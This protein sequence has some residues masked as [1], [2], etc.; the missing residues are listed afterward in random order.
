MA[1]VS[2]HTSPTATPGRGD[3]GGINVLQLSLARGLANRG[4]AVDLLTRAEA[5]PEVTELF[6]GVTL[7]TIAAGGAR[8]LPESGMADV[9]D[10]FGEAVATLVGRAAPRYDLLH[11]HFWLSGL[12]TLPVAL[13]LGLPFVQSFHTLGSM[14]NAALADSERP[15]P[16]RRLRAEAFL[17]SEADAVVAAS[18]AEVSAL[19]DDLH[20]PASHMWVIPP[21]VDTTLFTPNRAGHA[22]ELRR[23]LDLEDDRPLMVMAGRIEPIKAQDLAIRILAAVH[24]LHGWAP[25]LVVAGEA[26][27]GAEGYRDSLDALAE[28][29]GV[30]PHLRFVGPLDRIE[31]ADL[32]AAAAV[33]L[34][35]SYSETFGLVALESAA[36]GTP[37]VGYRSAGLL[38][39][40]AEG[41]S[42]VLVPTRDPAAW[43]RTVSDLLDDELSLARLSASAR[44]HAEGFTWATATRSLLGVYES[45][46]GRTGD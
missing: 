24:S 40:V 43:A 32:F 15:E 38:E 33:T 28:D 20:A 25:L 41:E 12:A 22:P 30:T 14:K 35:T 37:V 5:E 4:I 2:M 1:M 26:P 21:G 45:L 19:I 11:A 3:A 10:A 34:I 46:L 44:R 9:A 13:E 39:S 29:L 18:S 8:H 42:G 17:A 16:L 7:R 27:I 23:R 6:P 36:S 31:L